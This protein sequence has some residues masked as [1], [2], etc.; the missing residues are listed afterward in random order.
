MQGGGEKGKRGESGRSAEGGVETADEMSDS[1]TEFRRTSDVAQPP[2]G[3]SRRRR[4][5]REGERKKET[6][7]RLDAITSTLLLPRC[8]LPPERLL[9]FLHRPLDAA[10]PRTTHGRRE[11]PTNAVELVHRDELIEGGAEFNCDEGFVSVLRRRGRERY[12]GGG[13]GRASGTY[14]KP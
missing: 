14:G 3:E 8:Q 5:D 7:S 4:R 12:R 13:T 1:L 6:S 11:E 10:P 2:G 9:S